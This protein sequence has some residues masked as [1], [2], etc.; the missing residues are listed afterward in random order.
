LPLCTPV[1]ASLQTMKEWSAVPEDTLRMHAVCCR[2]HARQQ[3]CLYH[4]S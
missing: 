2:V 3:F 4:L 1:F